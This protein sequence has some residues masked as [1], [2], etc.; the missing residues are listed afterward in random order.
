MIQGG[1]Q[2]KPKNH[3]DFKSEFYFSTP[4]WVA[5]APMFLKSMTKLTNKYIKKAEKNLKTKFKKR[6]KME[7]SYRRFWFIKT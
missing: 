4:I 5:Q 7:T 1:S 2:Q 6:T 3:V